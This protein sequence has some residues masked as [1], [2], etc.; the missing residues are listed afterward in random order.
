MWP[1]CAGLKL[2]S[3]KF[4]EVHPISSNGSI[5]PKRI[6][7]VD[8]I[9]TKLEA[10][11]AEPGPKSGPDAVMSLDSHLNGHRASVR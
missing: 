7:N 11:Q 8:N 9:T 2:T 4:D 3:R 10:L 6:K 5:T 1:L